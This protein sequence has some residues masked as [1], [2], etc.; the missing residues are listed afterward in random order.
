MG[1]HEIRLRR[2]RVTA[3]GSDRFRNYNTIVKR[4][5]Q[6]QRIKKNV[7]IFVFFAIVLILILVFIMVNRWEEKQ[8]KKSKASISFTLLKSNSML[9]S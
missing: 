2:Q 3:R 1:K 5:E 9:R 6:D 4:H 7:R 8:S